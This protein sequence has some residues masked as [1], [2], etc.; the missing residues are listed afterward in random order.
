MK[1]KTKLILKGYAYAWLTLGFFLVSLILHWTF[2]WSAFV[3]DAAEHGQSPEFG[4]YLVQMSRDTF[5]NAQFTKEIVKPAPGETWLLVTSAFHMPRSMGLFRK[6]GFEVT[7][8]DVFVTEAT[9]GLP[10]FRHP[11]DAGEIAKLLHSVRL[12]PERAHLVGARAQ[13]VDRHAGP[14][15]HGAV[16]GC[17][18]WLRRMVRRQFPRDAIG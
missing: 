6:V 18:Q 3:N 14:E 1:K 10:V 13:P 17:R 7:P 5:E 2:G 12:F 11:D 15:C 16:L 9:F 8:C 4:Q